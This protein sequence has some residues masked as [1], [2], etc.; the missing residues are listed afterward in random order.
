MPIT[1]ST[2]IKFANEKIRVSADKLAQCY[3]HCTAILERW[4]SLGGG[5]PAIDV[6]QN[7]IRN[8]ADLLTETYQFC[9]LVEKFWFI[10]GSTSMIPNDSTTLNDGSPADGRPASTGQKCVSVIDRVVQFQ[11]WLLSSAGSFT[12]TTRANISYINTVLEV[13]NNGPATMSVADAGNFINRCDEL[14]TNYEANTN[15]NLGTILALAVNPNR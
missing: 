8:C 11:N 7:D 1:D 3:Y 10:L 15:Q 6:M 4:N 12:D 5:Q 13:S 9:F 14:K 2:A